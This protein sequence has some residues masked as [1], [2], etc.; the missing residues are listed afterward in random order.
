MAM[1]NNQRVYELSIVKPWKWLNMEIFQ[2]K[3]HHFAHGD[4]MP[5]DLRCQD[6]LP[7]ISQKMAPAEIGFWTSRNQKAMSVKS[8]HDPSPS[9]STSA[10][11]HVVSKGSIFSTCGPSDR[12]VRRSL[13]SFD[14]L[15]IL[16]HGM[17]KS[18]DP[19]A[20]KLISRLSSWLLIIAIPL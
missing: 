6:D 3:D 9:K 18:Q 12:N 5:S 2:R 13:R 16:N 19:E 15:N 7:G 8:F 4:F 1:L 14:V 20:S 10:N 11:H 17:K